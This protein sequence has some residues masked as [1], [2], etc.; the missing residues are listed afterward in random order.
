MRLNP[1]KALAS[2]LLLLLLCA[3]APAV[4]APTIA[5]SLLA[6]LPHTSSPADRQQ[7]YVHLAD[8]GGDSLS[9]AAP[10]W[11][12]ALS[13]AHRTGDVYGCKEALDFLVRKFAG[14]D[15]ERS[16][17]YVKLADSILPGRR[18]ALFR[19]S[20]NAYFV[21]KQMNDNNSIETIK[22]ELARLKNKNLEKLTPEERIEWEFMTGLAVNYSSLATEAY[23]NI[24]EA[25]P[26][27]EHALQQVEKY[28]AAERLHFEKLCHDELADLYILTK[29]KR[30]AAEVERCIELHNAWLAMENRFE[31]PHRDT[32]GYLM[33]AYAKMVYMRDLLSKEQATVYFR[34]CI[35]L[36]RAMGDLS[37]LY[38]VSAR[39]Y[40]YMGE[41]QRAAA[42][43]D[44]TLRVQRS[45][46]ANLAPVYA[47]QSHLYEKTGDY[48]K[49]LEAL[50]Q[51]NELRYS[52]RV[53]EAQNELAEM[54]TLFDVNRLEMEKMQ[55]SG[56][57][58]LTAL[59]ACAILLLL[60]IGWGIYQTV[61]VRRLKQIREQLLIANEEISRQ[62]HRAMESE[63]MKT[64][65]INSM[66]HEIRTPLNAINGFSE[67]LLVEDLD[68]GTRQEFKQQ[69]WA[70]T[71]ALTD[72]LEN[73]LELSGLV[74]TDAPIPLTETDLCMLCAERLQV[75]KRQ[76]S[77]PSVEYFFR[78]GEL[79]LRNSF[80][81]LLHDAGD[82][83]PA[84]E[85]RQVHRCGLRHALL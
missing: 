14:R 66:C 10:Y 57:V 33:R 65:F 3:A 23:G 21:W 30:A 18:H 82:R 19:A 2:G 26:Y 12:A 76:S 36:A 7:L 31:R 58:R 50:R 73:M 27:V 74:S 81:R 5:D 55:L 59:L 52:D 64:A 54:Q 46:N 9:L 34:K 72:L 84:P 77:N 67:L 11:E 70:N 15:P 68:T 48:R 62:S 71:T 32:T 28:P 47:V 45:S 60:F 20:L 42:Y 40:Q 85:R 25:I 8:L 80:K 13:E 35:G 49:A 29:D 79:R 78:G 17:R 22:I 24:R 41:Y 51:A 83:Q 1:P 37:Q 16:R 4:C 56:R 75:Q 69:I 44:S 6:R 53:K 63:K 39:Y 38:Y 43:I 61:M